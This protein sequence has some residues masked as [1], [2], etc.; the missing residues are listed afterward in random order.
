MSQIVITGQISVIGQIIIS[1]PVVVDEFMGLNLTD[2]GA[3]DLL[4]VPE[5]N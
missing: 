5:D 1:D 2:D 3:L 4:S